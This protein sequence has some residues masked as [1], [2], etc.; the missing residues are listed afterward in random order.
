MARVLGEE[1]RSRFALHRRHGSNRARET[2]RNG[3]HRRRNL[4]EEGP[5]DGTLRNL[6]IRFA[7]CSGLATAICARRMIKVERLQEN[8]VPA[9]VGHQ[10][11]IARPDALA[12]RAR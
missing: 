4:S 8:L 9:G 3:E 6:L 11:S 7:R 5:G 12:K 10:N 1:R 2:S